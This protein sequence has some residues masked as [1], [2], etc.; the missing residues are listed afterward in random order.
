MV[1]KYCLIGLINFRIE[2]R[3][4]YP[5]KKKCINLFLDLYTF[6]ETTVYC[7]SVFL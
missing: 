4:L 3:S 7:K 2:V 6:I 5:K 1:E